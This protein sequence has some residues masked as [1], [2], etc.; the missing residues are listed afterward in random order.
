MAGHYSSTCPT[1]PPKR[2]MAETLKK[3]INKNATKAPEYEAVS[4]TNMT[5]VASSSKTP[6]TPNA[7]Y[8]APTVAPQQYYNPKSLL[9]STSSELYGGNSL[10]TEDLERDIYEDLLSPSMGMMKSWLTNTNLD[11]RKWQ[12]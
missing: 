7:T 9:T 5:P 3:G 2:T 6:V 11:M 10:A 8:S 4:S 1:F 12:T